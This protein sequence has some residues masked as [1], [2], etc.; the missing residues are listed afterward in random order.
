VPLD[1]H[2]AIQAPPAMHLHSAVC[3]HKLQPERTHEVSVCMHATDMHLD[4]HSHFGAAT[5]C[6]AQR[7]AWRYLRRM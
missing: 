2:A 1:R 6:A 7:T 3:R 5:V 4:L